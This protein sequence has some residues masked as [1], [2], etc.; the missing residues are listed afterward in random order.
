[1][2]QKIPLSDNFFCQELLEDP[3]KV[4]QV[5]VGM[6]TQRMG[7]FDTVHPKSVTFQQ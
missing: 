6:I 7:E 5:A 4:N 3:E 1:M 2:L